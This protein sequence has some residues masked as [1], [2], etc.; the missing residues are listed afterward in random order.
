MASPIAPLD[1]AK[2]DQYVTKTGGGGFP[3]GG[4]SVCFWEKYP[5]VLYA[6]CE[7]PP[8]TATTTGHRCSLTWLAVS[9]DR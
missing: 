8:T 6:M 5:S 7:G 9:M 2:A 4:A 1:E 3:H